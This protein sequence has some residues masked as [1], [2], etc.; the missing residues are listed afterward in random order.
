MTEVTDAP[1]DATSGVAAR[2]AATS[3]LGS[4]APRHD[5]I[6]TPST[7]EP[8]ETDLDGTIAV[9][10]GS[11]RGIGREIARALARRRCS[12][13]GVDRDPEPIGSGQASLASPYMTA[14]KADI[15]EPSD[16]RQVI[17]V[18]QKQWGRIDVLVNNA[19]VVHADPL[20]ELP[21]E[22]WQRVFRI[23]AEGTFLMSQACAALMIAQEP[24]ESLGR[25]GTLV[26]V[27]S[28]AAEWGRP[29]MAGY[30]ASKAAVNHMTQ[31]FSDGLREAQVSCFGVCPGNHKEGMWGYLG[32]MIAEASGRPESDVQ[33]ERE[34]H[35]AQV[36]ADVVTDAIAVPG[37][38]LT[39][40]IV[41]WDR[42][43]TPI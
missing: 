19:G 25:R 21:L 2:R 3:K 28:L 38:T 41:L 12:V 9:V 37:L 7:L 10:T 11:G 36:F 30:G 6:A 14:L 33:N 15:S 43:I 23:N 1:L 13:L 35:S 39:N 8:S 24:N 32:P 16:V 27:T 40:T 20:L 17:E 4:I 34:F 26:N 18:A 5:P 22:T 42:Q 29:L 31:S